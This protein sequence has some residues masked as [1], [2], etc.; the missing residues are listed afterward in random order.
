MR[1][2]LY[3][4]MPSPKKAK[5]EVEEWKPDFDRLVSIRAL[6]QGQI[7]INGEHISPD[8]YEALRTD[9]RVMQESTLLPL[10][11]AAILNEAN[12]FA[13]EEAQITDSTDIRSTKLAT[14]Q[15]IAMTQTHIMNFIN[16]LASM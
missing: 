2:C 11:A 3:R 4:S 8:M 9:A 13:M 14:A 1:K 12:R 5:K 15:G 16:K 6:A 7:I 10:M